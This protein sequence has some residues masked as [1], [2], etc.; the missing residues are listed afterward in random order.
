LPRVV[1]SMRRSSS[2]VGLTLAPR[3]PH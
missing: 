3:R 1:D 2:R